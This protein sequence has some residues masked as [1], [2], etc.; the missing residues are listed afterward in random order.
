MPTS[1]PCGTTDSKFMECSLQ[2]L[3][4]LMEHGD[5]NMYG[6][7]LKALILVF[8]EIPTINLLKVSLGTL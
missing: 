4:L 7:N 8:K 3:V 5:A 6:L 1:R 2:V